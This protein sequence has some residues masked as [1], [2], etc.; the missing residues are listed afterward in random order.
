V[1]ALWQVPLLRVHVPSVVVPFLKVTVPVAAEGDTVAVSVT[2]PPTDAVVAEEDSVVVVADV[3][4]T[5]TA[6]EVLAAYV[7]VAV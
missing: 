6:A 2:L 4:A 3:T 7:A 5:L 1:K